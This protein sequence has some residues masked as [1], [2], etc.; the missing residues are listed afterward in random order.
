[1]ASVAAARSGGAAAGGGRGAA[2]P[3]DA[4]EVGCRAHA[5]RVVA[6]PLGHRSCGARAGRQGCRVTRHDA[7]D[8]PSASTDGASTAAASGRPSGA[9][10]RTGKPGQ[11]GGEVGRLLTDRAQGV[12]H[13]V[14]PVVEHALRPGLAGD[15]E[16]G[17]HVVLGRG[18]GGAQGVELRDGGTGE[19]RVGSEGHPAT[20]GSCGRRAARLPTGLRSSAPAGRGGLGVGSPGG[21]RRPRRRCA[22][23]RPRPAHRRRS[24]RPHRRRH[25]ARTDGASA[26]PPSS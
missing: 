3:A 16:A 23:R 17:E 25:D 13:L 18:H 26:P 9:R 10:G 11:R 22:G 14:E 8:R 19:L 15:D 1:M 7:H 24:R 20:V 4:E 5:G 12:G 21:H 2:R 6:E